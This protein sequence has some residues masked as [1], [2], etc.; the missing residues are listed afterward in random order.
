[1]L[2]S[3]KVFQMIHIP[4]KLSFYLIPLTHFSNTIVFLL[5]VNRI[6]ASD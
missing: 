5:I 3:H 4:Q 1:M 6:F 2:L